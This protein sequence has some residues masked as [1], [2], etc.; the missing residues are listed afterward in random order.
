MSVLA[1]NCNNALELLTQVVENSL[2]SRSSNSSPDAVQVP[3][4]SAYSIGDS[5][6]N[7]PPDQQNVQ[8]DKSHIASKQPP[9][10]R[11]QKRKRSTYPDNNNNAISVTTPLQDPEALRTSIYEKFPH[12]YRICM[13]SGNIQTMLQSV[14]YPYCHKDIHSL[15][16]RWKHNLSLSSSSQTPLQVENMLE[17]F[18]H[19]ESANYCHSHFSFIPNGV[20]NVDNIRIY[21]ARDYGTLYTR[22]VS[23]FTYQGTIVAPVSKLKTFLP[24]SVSSSSSSSSSSTSSSRQNEDMSHIHTGSTPVLHQIFSSNQA[25]DPQHALKTLDLPSPE[26]ESKLSIFLQHSQFLKQS[27]K[28]LSL[29]QNVKKP[30]MFA[31]SCNTSMA[32]NAMEAKDLEEGQA[33]TANLAMSTPSE[34]MTHLYDASSLQLVELQFKAEGYLIFHFND[35]NQVVKK[36][37]HYRAMF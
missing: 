27:G 36:E 13:N 32:I 6:T 23:T 8:I 19:R 9:N 2:N 7:T 35:E 37:F 20:F 4:G 14:Y 16:K 28:F 18:S 15:F 33:S 31:L 3:K 25:C 34:Y 12:I 11:K 10:V 21:K 30:A 1:N 24:P 17:L 29:I 26:A 22:V 5:T